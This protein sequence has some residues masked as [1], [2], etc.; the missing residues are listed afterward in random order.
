[1]KLEVSNGVCTDSTTQTLVFNNEVK[2]DFD[3]PAVIC[4]E[5][6]LTVMDKST[7][8]IDSWNW[9][10]DIISS[11]NLQ[12]PPPLYFPNI[13]REVYYNIQ[14][15]VT[16]TLLNCTDSAR[17]YLQ[18][19]NNCYIAVP[20]AF[21]PNGDGLND[22]FWPH[23][24]LKADNLEFKVYNRWGQLVFHSSNWQQKWDGKVNG[25]PQPPGVFV[26]FLSYT[27]RDTGQKVFQKGTV[28]LIR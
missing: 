3:M 6:P 24:A 23:N 26:W 15:A 9:K 11:S 18:V 19:L 21:T 28:M 27:N 8:T 20:S 4:P 12:N 7:G 17:K 10:F 14:L 13:N 5:D 16:N 1:M 22:F 2:A 25:Q